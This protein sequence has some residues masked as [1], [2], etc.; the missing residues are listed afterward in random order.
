MGYRFYINKIKKDDL[1]KILACN[2]LE[3]V[4]PLFEDVEYDDDG[5][6]EYVPIW[7]IGETL[8]C[9]GKPFYDDYLSMLAGKLTQVFD[10]TAF[11]KETDEHDVLYFS[12]EDFAGLIKDGYVAGSVA[13]IDEEVWNGVVKTDAGLKAMTEEQ[14]LKLFM[15]VRDDYRNLS[16]RSFVSLDDNTDAITGSW[17]KKYSVFE[18]VRI[19][20][21][22]DWET[23]QLLI[24]GW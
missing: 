19:Y 6:V 24:I 8:Y 12:K 16:A 11:E 23:E 21:S 13:Y 4:A 2:S 14:I 7:G 1:S 10:G 22:I 18:L 17:N 15:Y 9:L 20:K 3:E 5:N